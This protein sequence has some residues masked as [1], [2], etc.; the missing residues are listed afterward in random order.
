MGRRLE[1]AQTSMENDYRHKEF[2]GMDHTNHEIILVLEQRRLALKRELQEISLLIAETEQ[3]INEIE[4]EIQAVSQE[5]RR[6][7]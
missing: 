6:A 5:Y 4:D 1:F 7:A 3:E 2:T